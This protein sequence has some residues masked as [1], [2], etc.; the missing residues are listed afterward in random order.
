MVRLVLALFLVL[1]PAAEIIVFPSGDVTLRGV[2]Y[3]PEGTGPFPAVVFNH[4]SAMDSSA[5]IDALGPVFAARGW[6]FFAPN[7]RGQ[8]LS[9]S[10]GPYIQDQIRAAVARGG[11]SEG[12][13]TLIRL[14]ETDH[15]N[16]QLAA[17]AWL[18]QAS[19]IQPNRIAVAGNSF[20]GIE[21]VLGAEKG[22]YCAALDA[23]G[24]A[25]SWSAAPELQTR[26]TSA[27]RHARA[28]IFF[29]QAEN[30]YDLSPSRTLAAAMKDSGKVFEMKI[31]PPF[32]KSAAEGHSF[33]YFGS[34]IWA[35]DVF[36][37]LE[38][39]CGRQ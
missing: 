12:A 28:P 21:A 38:R 22:T 6:V 24:A 7:R 34:S 27:V 20:G 4:G 23:A 8:G 18:R 29:F 26:M 16:D 19:F 36:R 31:Y 9:A 14:L 13:S 30:D 1:P 15:L 32:G 5:A 3:R 10:A 33:G 35:V 25:Q 17:L 37:F 2:L 39:H 11:M